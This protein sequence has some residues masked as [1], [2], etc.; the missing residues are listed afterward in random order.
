VDSTTHG[1]GCGCFGTLTQDEVQEVIRATLRSHGD[2]GATEDQITA[3][4][5]W[6]HRA[7]VDAEILGMILRGELNVHIPEEEE[8]DTRPAIHVS[9]RNKPAVAG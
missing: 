2:D 7:R 4:C 9:L 8:V 6:A 5:Q 1:E 3:A